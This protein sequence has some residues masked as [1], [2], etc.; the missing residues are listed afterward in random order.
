MANFNKV[1]LMGNLT[2]DPQLSYLPS[3]T[4]VV[5]IGLAVNRRWRDQ[6]GQQREDTCFI[7][8]RCFGRQ[9]EVINQYLSK[10]RPVLV[11]GR[12]DYDTWE[13][14]DGSKRS[15]H[16][17][18]IERFS[19]VDSQGGGGGGNNYNNNQ[20][21]QAPPMGGPQQAPPQNNPQN[22]QQGPPPS[23]YDEDSI[24]GEDIP[25]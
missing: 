6:Q 21:R 22:D 1:I 24:G 12:L 3:Q 17:V 20:T 10:G 5:E 25:F 4:P 18:T 14:Q 8:C 15:K 16:R 19:F 11:E 7:D 13:A 23:S 9:A 2:R